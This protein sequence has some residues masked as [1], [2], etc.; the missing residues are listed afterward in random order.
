MECVLLHDSALFNIVSL[1]KCIREFTEIKKLSL[2]FNN[3][4]LKWEYAVTRL[5]LCIEGLYSL[6]KY[7]LMQYGL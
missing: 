6:F 2:A 7:A 4:G 3:I 1:E 5:I